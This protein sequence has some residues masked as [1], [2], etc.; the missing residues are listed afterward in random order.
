MNKNSL[1]TAILRN[2]TGFG[3]CILDKLSRV[4]DLC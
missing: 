3:V 1:D 4:H 2:A